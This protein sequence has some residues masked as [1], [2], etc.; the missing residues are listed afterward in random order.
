MTEQYKTPSER[1]LEGFRAAEGRLRKALTAHDMTLAYAIALDMR[2]Y[3]DSFN[4][5][6]PAVEAMVSEVRGT[7]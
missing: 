2:K 6:N 3:F 7:K 4:L 5:H 1:V